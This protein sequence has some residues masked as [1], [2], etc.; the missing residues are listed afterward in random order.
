MITKIDFYNMIVIM[1]NGMFYILYANKIL[2]AI[3]NA[4]AG[5]T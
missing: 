3:L 2:F 4:K 1:V 5:D